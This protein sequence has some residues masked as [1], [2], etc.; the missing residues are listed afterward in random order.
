MKLTTLLV[1]TAPTLISAKWVYTVDGKTVASGSGSHGC[2]RNP[3]RAGQ[4]WKWNAGGTRC[5]LHMYG[6]NPGGDCTKSKRLNF[7]TRG[8]EDG[9]PAQTDHYYWNVS[10]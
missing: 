4:Q 6:E 8:A 5:V 9:G 2:A 3:L 10:C 1:L 7:T